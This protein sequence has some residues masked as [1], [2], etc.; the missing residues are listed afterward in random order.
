MYDKKL[1]SVEAAANL[2]ESDSTVGIGLGIS[3]PRRLMQAV[4]QRVD[5]G[6][7]D[8]L[9]LYYVRSS[10][11]FDEFLSYDILDKVHPYCFFMNKLEREWIKRGIAEDRKVVNFV[12][13]H[14]SN[15]PLLYQQSSINLDLFAVMTSAVDRFGYFSLGTNTDV[16]LAAIR[17][18]KKVII[19]TNKYMPYVYGQSQLHISDI[20]AIIE[21]DQPLPDSLGRQA[22]KVDEKIVQLLSEH[23]DDGSCLQIG[24]GGL[25]DLL[26][27]KIADRQDLGLHSELLS[28]GV[29]KL[30]QSG[31]M[32][33][34][35]KQIDNGQ[36]VFSIAYGDQNFY[37]F[38]NHNPAVSGYPVSY[39]NS[40]YVIGQNDRMISVNS[41]IEIDLFG[42]V[43]AEFINHRQYGGVGGQM[44]FIRG[45]QYSNGGKSFIA[46]RS[47]AKNGKISRIVPMISGMVTDSRMD[48]QYVVTEYG[49]VNLAGLSTQE[50]AIALIDLAHPDFR[51]SLAEHAISIK[52]VRSDYGR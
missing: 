40:P 12:P 37:Q 48:V 16:N 2:M 35:R 17:G 30:I 39:T 45:A 20:D 6:D 23:I 15:I 4:R 46:M 18:A 11:H 49:C 38:L 24:M 22:D 9:S 5:S 25:P 27:Q 1:M 8:K 47:T 43:N 33:G 26:C 13:C 29:A 10:P 41:A 28:M 51:D 3:A 42:Q 21:N 36:H 19:E 14:L 31:A 52:Q 34:R 32:T 44:D 7:L 50:R